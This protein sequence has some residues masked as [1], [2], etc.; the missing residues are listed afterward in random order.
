M[1]LF[2]VRIV[3]LTAENLSKLL[4]SA[5]VLAALLL[6]RALAGR[7]GRVHA[8]ASRRSIW[9]RKA[10]RLGAGAIATLLFLSIWF[11]NP[12]RLAT[13][14]GLVLAGLA[15]ASQSAV[16]SAAG[17]FVIVLG[18][19][20]DLGDR[21]QLGDVRGDVLDIGLFKTTVMEMGTPPPLAGEPNG[22]I[23]ARQYTGRVVT[24]P[25]S[26]VFRGPTYNYTRNF[27]FLWEELRVPVR[28]DADLAAAEAVLLGAAR[29][30]TREIVEEGRRSLGAMRSLYV[31]HAGDLEPRVY[32]RLTEDYVELAVRFLTRALGVRELKDQVAR[33]ILAGLRAE[34]IEIASATL[35][36]VRP[37]GER[38]PPSR[39]ADARGHA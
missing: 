2:G 22:W 8:G 38:R 27:D 19:T 25:N 5:G 24:V 23:T 3:G 21:V 1:E 30:A 36:V 13:F 11:D 20:F 16:L 18:R 10:V 26:E 35:E 33:S 14:S 31:I 34:R 17:Y 15:F 12:A 6:V 29:E 39:G 32:V 4:L 28:H 9:T 37:P 7:V